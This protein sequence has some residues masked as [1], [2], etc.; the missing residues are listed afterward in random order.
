M[1]KDDIVDS[2]FVRITRIRDDLQVIDE[3]VLEKELVSITLFGFPPSWSAFAS[4]INSWKENPTFEQL[5]NARSQEEVI[6][7]L[8]NTKEN[9]E[10]KISNAYFA[11]HK[12]KGTF[13]KFKG[14]RRKVDLSNI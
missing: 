10:E 2:F 12:N 1:T 4:G 13:K 7:Y 5:W 11:H 8:V 3:I 6:I 9:E 14:T